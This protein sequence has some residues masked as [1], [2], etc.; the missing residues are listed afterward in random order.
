MDD[1]LSPSE[2]SRIVEEGHAQE[3]VS[4]TVL[5]D[6]RTRD[7][8]DQ[9]GVRH[10]DILYLERQMVELMELFKSLRTL[11]DVQGESLNIIENHVEHSK[12]YVE[13]GEVNLQE[14]A[15]Y[16]G[17]TRWRYCCCL[18]ILGVILVVILVPTLMA[19]RS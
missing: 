10:S 2:I 16:Q 17:K 18:G 1:T 14:A 11:V 19:A 5:S 6:A 9:I 7:L 12:D 15:D 3:L 4:Q 13:R 8:V